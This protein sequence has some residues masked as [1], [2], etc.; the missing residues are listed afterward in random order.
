MLMEELISCDYLVV[1]IT[2]IKGKLPMARDTP[3][4]QRVTASSLPWPKQ[5]ADWAALSV[6]E[7]FSPSDGSAAAGMILRRQDGSVIFAVY[8]CIFN[9]NDALEAELHAIM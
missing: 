4:E 6:D 1:Y 5:P 2:I 7:A 3:V 8:R 9:C